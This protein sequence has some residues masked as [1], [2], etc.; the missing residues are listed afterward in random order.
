MMLRVSQKP[1]AATYAIKATLRQHVD[2]VQCLA[3]GT[4]GLKCTL[5]KTIQQTIL[6]PT[7]AKIALQISAILRGEQGA[8]GAQGIQGEQ[9]LKGDAGGLTTAELDQITTIVT[10][11]DPVATFNEVLT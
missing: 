1:S 10:G 4:Y 9:G 7:S 3:M 11:F 2:S 8:Q 6:L 5:K